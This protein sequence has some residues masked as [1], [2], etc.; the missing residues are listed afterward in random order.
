MP[1]S[2]SRL[3]PSASERWISCPASIR[4]GEKVTVPPSESTY[5]AE[6]TAAHELGEIA[7]SYAFGKINEVLFNVRVKRWRAAAEAAGYNIEE[8]YE[9]IQ[10]YVDL[11]RSRV[12]AYPHS[13]ILLEQRL[14]TGLPE[15]VG[16]SD[17]VIVGPTH[18]EVVD[19]K[20]GKGIRVAA[21]GN[22]QLRLYG[23]G[24]LEAFGDVLGDTK[25]VRITVYQPRLDSISWEEIPAD[26]LRAWRDGLLPVAQEALGPDA[27][28]GPSLTACRWCPAAGECRARVE[29]MTRIDF[30]DPDLITPEETADLL[31]R[32]P[33]IR[34]WCDALEST[35]LHRVYSGG[36][37]IPGWKVVLSGGRRYI[38]D[39][40]AAAELLISAGY[41]REDITRTSMRTLGDLESLVGKRD[42]PVLLGDLLKKGEGKPS[43]VQE[44]DQRK[45]VD[46][47]TE[48]QKEFQQ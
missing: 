48:A 42:L 7:A 2:H 44:S 46:P 9:H 25:T 39:P 37:E 14:A 16:T 34:N 3:S 11:L 27:H 31:A 47:N 26:E 33:D 1:G 38:T 21:E 32:L 24:A 6:G 15:C 17:A 12:D 19:L 30:G 43:L 18:V 20:Y 45:P 41:D 10:G 8:M 13:Q 28:F 5:A 22:P 35:A 23:I 40:D 29:Y 4:M 36:E